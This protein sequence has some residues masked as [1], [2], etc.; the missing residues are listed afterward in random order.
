MVRQMPRHL[1]SWSMGEDSEK[2]AADLSSR[3]NLQNQ[4]QV[5]GNGWGTDVADEVIIA[6]ARGCIKVVVTVP[7][8]NTRNKH[9]NAIISHM[10]RTGHT[11]CLQGYLEH[12]FQRILMFTSI[13]QQLYSFVSSIWYQITK[14]GREWGGGYVMFGSGRCPTVCLSAVPNGS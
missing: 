11:N 12:D 10:E 14:E 7:S 8:Y 13:L 9:N 5:R 2:D 3:V 4:F 6:T 1:I